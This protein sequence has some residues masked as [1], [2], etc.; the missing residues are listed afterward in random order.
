[1]KLNDNCAISISD[2]KISNFMSFQVAL[3]ICQLH[4]KRDSLS[5]IA[6]KLDLMSSL[7]KTQPTIQL[8]LTGKDFSGALDLI[9]TSRD[10]LSDDLR[11]IVSF[12]HLSS[13]LEEIQSFIGKMLL[14]DFKKYITDEIQREVIQERASVI[15]SKSWQQLQ[16]DNAEQLMSVIYG[17]LRQNSYTFLEVL[18]EASF[19]AVKNLLKDIVVQL[20]ATNAPSKSNTTN[21]TAPSLPVDHHKTTDSKDVQEKTDGSIG[22][23]NGSTLRTLSSLGKDYAESASSQEW[24]NFLNVLL[25]RYSGRHS[26]KN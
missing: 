5:S 9:T 20:I 14:G 8:F 7:H 11:G 23:L 21:T 1:M 26:F 13:Q 17:L 24:T 18:E 22:V 19:L 4:K 10:I 16:Q 6:R 12:R 3:E 15:A 25:G 2:I